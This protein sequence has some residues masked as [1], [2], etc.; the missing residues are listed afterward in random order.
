M[1][2][3]IAEHSVDL[4]LLPEKANIL[5]LGCRGFLFSDYFRNLGHHVFSVDIDQ[6]NEGRAYYQCAISDHDG[7]VGIQRSSDPQA[8][9]IKEGDTI[10][11]YTLDTFTKS[12]GVKMWDLI[13]CDV[14]GHEYQ[15][16]MSLSKAPAKS[17]SI[18]FHL[19]TGIYTQNAM[20]LMEN[21]LLYLGYEFALHEMTEAHGAGYNYWSSLFILP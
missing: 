19:H 14:E 18:E 7:R 9:R 17:L 16:I 13:K 6:L 8:T 12:C 4:D 10:P 20:V 15:I 21:K 5:D 3:T 2:S 1:I 11:C